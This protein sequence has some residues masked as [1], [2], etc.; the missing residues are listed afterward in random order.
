MILSI[1]YL[2]NRFTLIH[3]FKQSFQQNS[4][5]VS[6]SLGEL[7]RELSRLTERDRRANVRERIGLKAERI[8]EEC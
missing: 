1:K 6:E 2:P 4:L 3:N 5:P 8:R 7:A